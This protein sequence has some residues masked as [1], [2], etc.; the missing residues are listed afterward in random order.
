MVQEPNDRDREHRLENLLPWFVAVG[1]SGGEGLGDIKDLLAALP[2]D[3]DA[4][5]MVVLHRPWDSA[6]HLRDILDRV[7]PMSVLIAAQGDRLDAGSVYIG[8]PGEHLTLAARCL[9]TMTPDPAKLHRNRTVDLLFESVAENGGSR[10]IGVV[11]SGSLDD[12]SRGLAA[13]HDAGG[14]TMVINPGNDR[15]RGMPENAI[16]YDGP[17][18]AI[19]SAEEIAAAIIQAVLH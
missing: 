6:S 11:L 3:L 18:D 7:T 1:A 13:M 8:E 14:L 15:Y 17:I 16:H 5:V 9:G 4:V 12:G 19:G 10:T 2:L